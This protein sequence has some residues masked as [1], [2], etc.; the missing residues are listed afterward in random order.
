MNRPRSVWL[1]SGLLL[2]AVM[3]LRGWLISLLFRHDDPSP[4]C[5]VRLQLTGEP[6]G[7]PS[8]CLIKEIVGESK[9]V[10]LE[11]L[12]GK[13]SDTLY[14]EELRLGAG[15][16]DIGVWGPALFASEA[17][18]ILAEM[19]PQFAY[20]VRENEASHGMEAE[21]DVGMLQETGQKL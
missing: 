10:S 11:W 17:D 7:N 18:R 5:Q 9:S 3:K 16:L 4:R 12:G 8:E 21:E 20:L 2:E 13:V 1:K 6:P 15:T 14:H 19:R